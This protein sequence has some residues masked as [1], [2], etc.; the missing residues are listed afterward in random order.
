MTITNT[1]KLPQPLVNAITRDDYDDGGADATVT[2]LLLPPR[3]AALKRQH[4]HE[5]VED[6]SERIWSLIGRI[7]HRILSE[8]AKECL[9]EKRLFTKCLGWKISGQFDLINNQTIS[10]YKFVSAWSVK[11]GPRDEWV[12]QL[13]L[14]HLLCVQN[15]VATPTR[16]EIVAIL[17]DWSKLEV[18][19]SSDYPRSGVMVFNIPMW[20]FSETEKF[21]AERVVMHQQARAG[22]LPQCTDE[23]TWTRKHTWAV[24][25]NGNKR[26]TVV[27]FSQKSA[28]IYLSQMNELERKKYRIDYRPGERVRCENYCLASQFCQQFQQYKL[29]QQPQPQEAA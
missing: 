23:D 29:S 26:A 22:T 5:L 8:G 21:L 10:D 24:V 6:A 17:R 14:Y 19:R 7:G 1:A 20:P 11:D 13:N 15:G 18:F 27:L 4:R 3:L 25:K 9:A 28:E 16:L 12:Q 2:E